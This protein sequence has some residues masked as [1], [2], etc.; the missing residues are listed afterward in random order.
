MPKASQ[1]AQRITINMACKV[2]FVDLWWVGEESRVFLV[3]CQSS[4]TF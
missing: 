3:G 2:G 4:E 1:Q